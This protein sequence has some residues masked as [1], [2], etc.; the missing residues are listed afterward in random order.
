MTLYKNQQKQS[1][2]DLFAVHL[3]FMGIVVVQL[4]YVVKM[5]GFKMRH[6]YPI[7]NVLNLPVVHYHTNSMLGV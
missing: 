1:L 4:F 7:T 5:L 2:L 3:M 6:A